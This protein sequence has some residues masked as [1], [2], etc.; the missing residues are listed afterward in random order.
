MAD[1]VGAISLDLI[2]V[3]TVKK[4]LDTIAKSAQS[5]A[6]AAFFDV[7]KTAGE[8][9]GKA[10]SAPIEKAIDAAEESLDAIAK[11]AS[12]KSVYVPRTPDDAPLKTAPMGKSTLASHIV[13][14]SADKQSEK[15]FRLPDFKVAEDSIGRSNQLLDITYSKIGNLEEKLGSLK[16]KYE[17]ISNIKGSGSIEAKTVD[18]QISAV[19][20]KLILLQNSAD[21]TQDKISKALD[22]NGAV[23]TA[24][25]KMKG[26]AKK[27]DSA[28]KKA[29]ASV[30]NS[31]GKAFSGAKSKVS[32]SVKSIQ[33]KVSG[34]ARSVKSA[35]KS[36]FLMAGLYAA[37]RG[38]K[39]LIGDTVTQ[40]KEFAKSLNLIKANLQVAFTP[41]M[42]TIQPALNSLA[43]GFAA[44]SKQIAVVSAGL[45]GTTYKQAA[46]TTKKMKSVSQAAKKAKETASFDELNSIGSGSNDESGTDFGALDT[47]KYD[48]AISF[49]ERVKTMLMSAAS[50]VGPLMGTIVSKISECAPSFVSAGV[51]ILQSLLTGINQNAPLIINSAVSIINSLMIGLQQLLPQLSEFAVNTIVFLATAFLTVA[52]Q[53]ISCGITLLANVLSGLSQKIPELIPKAKEAIS[54]IVQSIQDNLPTIIKSGMEILLSIIQGIADMLPTLIP[55]AVS[56]VVTLAE[57]LIENLPMIIEA[58]INLIVAL[59]FGIINALPILIKKAPE[60]IKGLVDGIVG[61]IP[62]LLDAA[63]DIIMGLCDFLINNYD[64]IVES[65]F[66]I[67]GTLISG[68]ISAIPELAKGAA[69]LVKALIDKIKETDWLKVGKDILKGIGDGLVKGV[70]AIGD[71]IKKAASSI[72]GTFKDF[73][74]IHSPSRL[75]KSVIGENLALGI[76]EG[77]TGEMDSVSKSMIKAIPTP[78]LQ[79]IGTSYRPEVYM[80]DSNKNQSVSAASVASSNNNNSFGMSPFRIILNVSKQKLTEIV[81]DGINENTRQ[82]GELAID[83]V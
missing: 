66:E 1:S 42:Q 14:Q 73:F 62:K 20:E 50:S 27:T 83:L 17:E 12:K 61:A 11:R 18:S 28:F 63:I 30:G 37:F 79:M 19:Q 60:I 34:L 8:A 69:K 15:K 38:I 16:S 6:E 75:F 67:V 7:G 13:N 48:D 4:Q 71:S 3:N 22:G 47:A 46:A 51:Q 23:E 80:D 32:G 43:S 45:F 53:L 10:I 72:L 55:A 35:F 36:A 68:L 21:K 82:T 5:P 33:H 54:T 26:A 41:I 44:V 81:C 40:N 24:A 57:G 70:T 76:G 58:A 25:N 31:I 49:G 29:M 77:F 39:S 2:V 9:I 64:D 59:A 52:P 78:E 56:C 74:G 65:G